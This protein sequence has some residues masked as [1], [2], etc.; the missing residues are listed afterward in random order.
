MAALAAA[1][2]LLMSNNP[3]ALVAG[4]AV[5]GARKVA[6]A[7]GSSIKSGVGKAFGYAKGKFQDMSEKKDFEDKLDEVG[8]DR[9][10]SGSPS[11]QENPVQ[12]ST[13]VKFKTDLFKYMQQITG[14]SSKQ[15]DMARKDELRTLEDLAEGRSKKSGA[16]EKEKKKRSVGD[17]MKLLGL[18]ALGSLL[19]LA[20]LDKLSKALGFDIDKV[21]GNLKSAVVAGAAI[22]VAAKAAPAVAKAAGKGKPALDIKRAKAAAAKQGRYYDEKGELRDQKTKRFAK[23]TANAPSQLPGTKPA[24]APTKVPGG[25]AKGGAKNL[26]KAVAKVVGKSIAKIAAKSLPFGIGAVIGTALAAGKA[27]RGDWVGAALE[28]T[29]GATAFVP[30]IGSAVSLTASAASLARDVYKEAYGVFPKDDPS[31]DRD[32][33]MKEIP[34]LIAKEIEKELKKLEVSKEEMKQISDAGQAVGAKLSGRGKGTPAERKAAYE[35]EKKQR[36]EFK[37][38]GGMLDGKKVNF[39]EYQS[40]MAMKAKAAVIQAAAPKV[41]P[42]DAKPEN[43]VPKGEDTSRNLTRVPENAV[44]KQVSSNGEGGDRVEVT[45]SGAIDA[46]TDMGGN[47]V[48]RARLA[49]QKKGS[50]MIK[51]N[52]LFARG[53]RNPDLTF[54]KARNSMYA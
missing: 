18:T 46:G 20:A 42:T 29:A 1:T 25:E 44:T 54:T 50:E 8:V 7:V 34:A 22:G 40:G 35:A 26:R 19:G 37:A 10:G 28:F 2:A 47:T 27:L 43:V 5:A 24:G 3:D 36:E 12:E 45:S 32:K 13:F 31:P 21:V 53:S 52:K 39:K 38:S 4:A 51:M 49:A 14:I 11:K 23:G 16:P 30:G 41:M 9:S 15:L 33:R 48:T 17:W 6:G